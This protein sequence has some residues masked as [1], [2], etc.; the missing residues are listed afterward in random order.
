MSDSRA[1]PN[2]KKNICINEKL[3]EFVFHIRLT[4]LIRCFDGVDPIIVERAEDLDDGVLLG[5]QTGNGIVQLFGE[6]LI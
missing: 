2:S 1:F 5:A 6:K 3:L 4:F